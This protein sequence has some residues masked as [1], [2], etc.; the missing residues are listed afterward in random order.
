MFFIPPFAQQCDRNGRPFPG[1]TISFRDD[2]TAERLSVFK[3]ADYSAVHEDPVPADG[4]GRMPPIFVPP[5]DAPFRVVMEFPDGTAREV[6][7]L[8]T[9]DTQAGAALALLAFPATARTGPQVTIDVADFGRTVQVQTALGEDVNAVLPI[10]STVARGALIVI[11]NA[12]QGR[13][14]FQPVG[15]DTIDVASIE[16]AGASVTL[17]AVDNGYEALAQADPLAAT[18]TRQ[19]QMMIVSDKHASGVTGLAAG[20]FVTAPP[21]GAWT[22]NAVNT[23]EANTIAGGEMSNTGR[24]TLPAGAFNVRA[25]RR[26][27]GAI[28]AVLEFRS[29]TSA[30]VIRGGPVV[31]TSTV[32]GDALLEGNVMLTEPQTFELRWLLAGTADGNTLGEAAAIATVNEIYAEVAVTRIN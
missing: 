4:F 6:R 17:R 23:V 8:R 16:N 26:F 19:S 30:L 24:I 13:V 2:E 7:G 9:S 29:T 21:V 15:T 5:R 32:A 3:T 31:L 1:W 28:K 11:R 18:T 25:R 27:R 22:G 20:G 12:G 14:L 10:A